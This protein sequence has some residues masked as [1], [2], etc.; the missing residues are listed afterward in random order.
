MLDWSNLRLYSDEI[1]NIR[2]LG[3]GNNL[4]NESQ[5]EGQGCISLHVHTPHK[6]VS[7]KLSQALTPL[8][9]SNCLYEVKF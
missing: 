6:H 8:I 9:F 1:N 7:L 3:M 5:G 2:G 4:S